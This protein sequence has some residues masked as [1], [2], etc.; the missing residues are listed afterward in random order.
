MK[1]GSEVLLTQEKCGCL[2]AALVFVVYSTFAAPSPSVSLLSL[3]Y[4]AIKLQPAPVLP[5]GA[6]SLWDPASQ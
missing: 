2:L 4:D 5:A 6:L 1:R 3:R